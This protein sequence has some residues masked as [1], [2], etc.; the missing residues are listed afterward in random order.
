[1]VLFFVGRPL[2]REDGSVFYI[3]CWPLPA[4]PLLGPSPLVLVTIFYCL[5][6]ETSHFVASYDSQGHGGGIRPRLHT[7]FSRCHS[8][9]CWYRLGTD[10]TENR[11]SPYCRRCHCLVTAVYIV[12]AR[13]W[14]VPSPWLA[15]GLFTVTM[16]LPSNRHTAPSL[17]LFVPNSLM[18]RSPFDGFPDSSVLHP[19]M[20]PAECRYNI[21]T[22]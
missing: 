20:Q 13:H 11:R 4:Q 3:C 5:R 6:F 19:S 16:L 8:D 21:V 14:L 1:M 2:W 9:C 22:D 18:V 15:S 7:G 12:V 10:R 17:R